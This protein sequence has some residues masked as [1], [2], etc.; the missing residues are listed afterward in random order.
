MICDYPRAPLLQALGDAAHY[1][2]YD[3]DRVERMVLKNI[4]GD[5]FPRFGLGDDDACED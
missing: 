5:F 4:Q 2:L 3:L 1:S